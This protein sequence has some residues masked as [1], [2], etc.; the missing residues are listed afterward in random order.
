MSNEVTG[1]AGNKSY[2]TTLLLSFFLGGLGIHRFYTGYIGIGVFQLITGGGC[3]IWALIDFISL[4]FG[5]FKDADDN[6][7]VGYNPTLGL[8]LFFVGLAIILFLIM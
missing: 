6:E 5:K 3:G 7:L 1:M 2:T 8:V 4:C